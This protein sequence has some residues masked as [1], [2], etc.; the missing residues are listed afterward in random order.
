M[1][2][3]AREILGSVIPEIQLDNVTLETTNDGETRVRVNFCIYDLVDKNEIGTWFEQIEYEQYFRPSIKLTYSSTEFDRSDIDELPTREDVFPITGINLPSTDY[4]SSDGY[5]VNKFPFEFVTTLPNDPYYLKVKMTSEFDID[6]LEQNEGIDL[7]FMGVQYGRARY[8]RKVKSQLLIDERQAKYPFQDFRSRNLINKLEIDETGIIAQFNRRYEE[9]S[10][11]L[12]DNSSRAT[13]FMSDFLLTRNAQ[14]EAKFLFIFDARSFYNKKSEYRRYFSR[15]TASDQRT[16]LLRT[17][18]NSLKILRKRV[19]LTSDGLGKPSVINFEDY[20]SRK[21]LCITRKPANNPKF[22]TVSNDTAAIR[23]I[24]IEVENATG[25]YFITGTDYE[26]ARKNSGAY[27]YG[28]SVNIVDN[29]KSILREKLARLESNISKMRKLYYKMS[30]PENYDAILNLSKKSLQGIDPTAEDMIAGIISDFKD[31]CS[32]FANNFLSIDSEGNPSKF[33]NLCD[34]VQQPSPSPEIIEV[35]FTL[36]EVLLLKARSDIGE[37]INSSSLISRKNSD[38]VI[39]SEKYY[40]TPDRIFDASVAKVDGMEYLVDFSE[41]LSQDALEEISSLA[42][43]TGGIGLKTIDAATFEKRFVSEVER[44]FSSENVLVSPELN[45]GGA[46]TQSQVSVTGTGSEYFT[47]SAFFNGNASSP[48]SVFNVK[49]HDSLKDAISENIISTG[50][51]D[52]I[53]KLAGAPLLLPPR[54]SKEATFLS[55]RGAIF[56]DTEKE[57]TLLKSELGNREPRGII[58]EDVER[59]RNAA[60]IRS[61]EMARDF[62]SFVFSKMSK[63]L[64]G[65]KLGTQRTLNN[66]SGIEDAYGAINTDAGVELTEYENTPNPFKAFSLINTGQSALTRFEEQSIVQG[67][68]TVSMSFLMKLEYLSGFEKSSD[69]ENL[70]MKPIFSSLTLDV[71]RENK[72]RNLLCRLHKYS[73]DEFGIRK[74]ATNKPVFDSVFVVRPAQ[75]D[76]VAENRIFEA[77]A[78]ETTAAEVVGSTYD[79]VTDLMNSQIQE[80]RN[81]REEMLID[82]NTKAVQVRRLEEKITTKESDIRDID[83]RLTTLRRTLLSG[84]VSGPQ[85][86]FVRMQIR[87]LEE[88]RESLV[89]GVSH[90]QGEIEDFLSEIA[91]LN[92]QI[93][94]IEGEINRLEEIY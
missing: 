33:Q 13:D 7:S 21:T 14:G 84:S 71:Y 46:N 43:T 42:S 45:Q 62:E 52:N 12:E 61:Q 66:S 81:Q 22:T 63:V 51:F 78:A 31:T 65:P 77:S 29:L 23:Q 57:I 92:S 18:I 82:A 59:R 48:T 70:V 19:R 2:M 35:L 9:A 20:E 90:H 41:N 94:E 50:N 58:N 88:R 64:S 16:I 11:I 36:M 44:Y 4:I 34:S 8:T 67:T 30:S 83:I 53:A 39:D 47:P 74:T 15:L 17:D 79:A 76:R 32:I 40:D 60:E 6:L 80:L 85:A 68:Y 3:T 93:V 37:P 56:Y 49:D 5:R 69:G 24:D 28:V 26:V 86:T 91:N 75:V 89:F 25:L 38:N 55:Q 10:R 72:N 87:Q 1:V 54:G 27:A 73:L